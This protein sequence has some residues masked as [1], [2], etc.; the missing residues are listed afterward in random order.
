MGST[1]CF[2]QWTSCRSWMATR[3]WR[4][5]RIRMRIWTDSRSRTGR[6]SRG[7]PG[8]FMVT[9]TLPEAYAGIPYSATLQATG[10]LSYE[11]TGFGLP[12]WLTLNATTGVLSGTPPA[13]GI[14]DFDV[15][16]A[17]AAETDEVSQLQ[18][19]ALTV[20]GN[21][22]PPDFTIALSPD[23][24][25]LVKTA[26]CASSSTV[27]IVPAYG[28]SGVVEL[29]L[30]ASPSFAHLTS[31]AITP[32]QTSKVV[33]PPNPCPAVKDTLTVTGK[34]GALTHTAVL[35]V[36]PPIPLHCDEFVGEGP[37]PL[38]CK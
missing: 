37:K 29:T 1:R 31:T 36:L 3:R 4:F 25:Q 34:S 27:T 11:W 15:Q 13:V 18:F 2:R 17:N 28:F 35:Q 6:T 9:T 10:E 22:P 38:L 5:H 12:S 16:A 19:L 32:G 14:L 8:P 20:G 26:G 33:I 24:V 23:P 30:S 7:P 21:P